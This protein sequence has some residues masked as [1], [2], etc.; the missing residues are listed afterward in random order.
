MRN[1]FL[2]IG[3]AS[4]LA[5]VACND[6]TGPSAG[7]SGNLWPMT[8]GNNWTY[9]DTDYYDGSYYTVSVIET[10]VDMS[11]G[12]NMAL[13][14]SSNEDEKWSDSVYF[15]NSDNYI[16][17]WIY[18][19]G[20]QSWTYF[21]FLELPLAIGKTWQPWA[22]DSYT[23]ECVSLDTTIAVEAGTF[24]NCV[25]IKSSSEFGE[26]YYYFTQGVGLV[27]FEDPGYETEQLSSYHV[28]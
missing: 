3:L 4:L 26:T 6:S 8:L 21:T 5:I 23:M 2:I 1:A 19:G 13:I 28:E 15:E 10:G 22:D 11:F 12:S 20:S 7:T 24:E 18:D 9:L 25:K 14:V 16:R 27:L 17:E